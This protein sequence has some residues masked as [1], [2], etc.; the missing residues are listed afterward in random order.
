MKYQNVR[1]GVFISRPN[2]FIAEV[3]LDGK[4]ERVHVKNTGRC[5]ELLIPGAAVYLQKAANP[6]RSTRY[7]LIAVKKDKR[8]INM[9]S[10]APN[11]AFYEYLQN[12]LH[13]DGVTSI[14][15]ETKYGSS[16]F[17]F[18]V[19]TRNR[20][21]FI[22]VKGVTLEEDGIVMFPDAPTERGVKHLNELARCVGEG[23][24]AQ[25]VF[26]AQMADVRYF[27]PNDRTHPAF[28]DAL[29]S[30]KN[31]GVEAMAFGC[32]VTPDSMTIGRAVEVRINLRRLR[33]AVGRR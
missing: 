19:E 7:D 32:A 1:G 29:V 33:P 11:A 24:E 25:A 10:G 13:I 27:T 26:V 18:Y 23:Y 15:P 20:R 3:E 6:N 14:R 8:L 9:D 28:G 30:A 31:M 17:D 22:E 5:R 12:G 21:I 16:R 2:R 4:S